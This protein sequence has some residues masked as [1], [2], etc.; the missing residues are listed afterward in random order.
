VKPIVLA[1][2]V[3]ISFYV[4]KENE[5]LLRLIELTLTQ[6]QES[7]IENIRILAAKFFLF[8]YDKNNILSFF[9]GHGIPYSTSSWGQEYW[10]IMDYFGYVLSDVGYVK[11]YFYWGLMGLIAI[12]FLFKKI[13]SQK[14]PIRF[15]YIKFYAWFILLTNVA[16][17]NFFKDIMFVSVILYI[18]FKVL[19]EKK[20]SISK[21]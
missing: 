14:V 11:I 18:H 9:V 2:T 5:I 7:G 3:S 21:K 15:E 8:E 12:A 10:R 17:H 19:D 1:F 6:F 4:L 20:K 13:L 16:S